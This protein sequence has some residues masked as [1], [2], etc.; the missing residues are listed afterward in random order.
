M[1]PNECTLSDRV[2]RII[3]D[4]DWIVDSDEYSNLGSST[5]LHHEM[6]EVDE[7]HKYC[8]IH[9]TGQTKKV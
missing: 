6:A 2:R 3:V 8:S 7:V 5:S 1:K 9:T 4:I